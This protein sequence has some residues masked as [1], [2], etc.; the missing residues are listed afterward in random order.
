MAELPRWHFDRTGFPYLVL[1]GT[2]IAV[3]LFP[4]T[5]TQFEC[6]LAEPS[7]P[8]DEWYLDLQKVSPR[9][10]W[11]Q[12]A[13]TPAWGCFVTGLFPAEY[14]PFISWLGKGYRL[15]TATEWRLADKAFQG[16]RNSDFQELSKHFE[17]RNTTAWQMAVR[18]TQ[19]GRKDWPSLCF[20]KDG[21]LEWVTQPHSEPG[22]LGRPM[23]ELP[24][25]IIIDPQEFAPVTLLK[26]ERHPA[27]GA[28][29]VVSL[30]SGPPR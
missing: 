5:K 24:I 18:F 17:G 10:N 26:P 12:E 4:A 7:G 25:Q 6:W 13:V 20:M 28:R 21:L 8:G 27:F 14:Q 29:L 15:P 11:R 3:S 9:T 30:R 22:G 16:L 2:D 1:N 19:L 23:A